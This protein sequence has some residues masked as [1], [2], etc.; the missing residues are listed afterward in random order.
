[1]ATRFRDYQEFGPQK[2]VR[3]YQK[4]ERDIRQKFTLFL[5]FKKY[6][7]ILF[8]VNFEHFQ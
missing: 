3:K 2:W 8:I 5:T 1:M 6:W 4:V 7:K